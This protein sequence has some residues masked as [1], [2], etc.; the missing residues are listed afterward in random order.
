MVLR[1]G[2]LN[3]FLPLIWQTLA[4]TRTV[5]LSLVS[6]FAGILLVHPGLTFCYAEGV[7]ATMNVST[8]Q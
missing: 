4:I 2:S 8:L 6:P 5:Q 1:I 7:E 3:P